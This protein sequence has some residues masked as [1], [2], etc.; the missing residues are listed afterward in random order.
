MFEKVSSQA[1][2]PAL[3]LADSF[4]GFPSHIKSESMYR[5]SD[6]GSAW[7]PRSGFERITMELA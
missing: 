5:T 6:G 3:A 2:I 7:V 4:L 1:L